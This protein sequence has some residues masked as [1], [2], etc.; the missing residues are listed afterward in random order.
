MKNINDTHDVTDPEDVVV[1][2][3]HPAT[4]RCNI[5]PP[6]T[7]SDHPTSVTWLHHD[8]PIPE[9]DGRRTVQEDG[10]LYIPKVTAGGRRPLTGSYRCK[11]Q[12]GIGA[13]ISGEA[14]LQVA[15]EYRSDYI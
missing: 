15:C 3:G 12:N 8:Q 14:K 6:G 7:T 2:K 13:V 11:V 4:L 1:Q 9:D 5:R 10:S